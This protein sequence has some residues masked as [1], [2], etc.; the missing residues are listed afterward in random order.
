MAAR[1]VPV[2]LLTMAALNALL[3]ETGHWDEPPE[4]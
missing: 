2:D 3:L 4:Q 1:D